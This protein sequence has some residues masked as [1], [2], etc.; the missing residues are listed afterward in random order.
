MAEWTRCVVK[1]DGEIAIFDNAAAHTY[2]PDH[3]V[4]DFTYDVPLETMINPLNRGRF[5]A[6]PCLRPGDDQAVT[7]S[8]TTQLRDPGDVTGAAYAT[9]QDILHVYSGGYVDSVWV[10]TLGA[11][12]DVMTYTVTYTLDGSIHGTADKTLTFTFVRLVGGAAEGDPGTTSVNGTS[13]AVKP[14]LS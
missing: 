14:V 3:E 13:Y 12:A 5:G 8:W 10:S 4:G 9:M 11:N 7:L 2:V 6:V 1:R